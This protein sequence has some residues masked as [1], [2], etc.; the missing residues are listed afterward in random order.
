A[1]AGERTAIL[2]ELDALEKSEANRFDTPRHIRNVRENLDR[3]GQEEAAA[4]AMMWIAAGLE[5]EDPTRGIRKQEE[6]ALRWF[7]HAGATA[8]PG[9]DMWKKA[10]LY[11]FNRLMWNDRKEAEGLLDVIEA[12]SQ[13]D[14]L[15][16]ARV[17]FDRMLLRLMDHDYDAAEAL[18]IRVARWHRDHPQL[19]EGLK[20]TD[21]DLLAQNAPEVYFEALTSASLPA[22][23]R[24]KRI[25]RVR[26]QSLLTMRVGEAAARAKARIRGEPEPPSIWDLFR[27]ASSRPASRPASPPAGGADT[28]PAT[29]AADAP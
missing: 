14:S 13:S 23:D 5:A 1:A 12:Q 10:N 16:Q 2:A 19:P 8:P 17:V 20:K 7:R 24:I 28:A 18:C 25:D 27:G 21:L 22:E 11:L 6:A 9:T 3:P 26:G 29:R 15:T 4:D